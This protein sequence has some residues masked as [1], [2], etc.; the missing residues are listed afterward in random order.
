MHQE[1]TEIILNLNGLQYTGL[2]LFVIIHTKIHM[3][4][5]HI[6]VP[7]HSNILLGSW[8]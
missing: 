1:S 3:K 2:V 7:E 8:Y 6:Q 5:L 4:Y